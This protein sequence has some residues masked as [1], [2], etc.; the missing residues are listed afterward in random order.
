MGTEAA[1]DEC[2]CAKTP[3]GIRV[4]DRCPIHGRGQVPGPTKVFFNPFM[5]SIE[6]N[7]EFL[8]KGYEVM[9]L[10]IPDV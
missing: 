6:Q 10:R 5:F 8:A 7:N 1:P 2:I 4:S 9:P 3:D